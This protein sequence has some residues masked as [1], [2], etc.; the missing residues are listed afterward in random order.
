MFNQKRIKNY[1]VEIGWL[2]SGCYNSL[3]DIEGVT[4]R[5]VTLSEQEIQT[6][7][8]T[9]LPHQGN[10]FKEKLIASTHIINGFRKSMG[11]I[12]I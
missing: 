1:G 8:T 4:V 5:K 9:I 3:T 11:S 7:V 6:G 10:L 12:Q 2:E